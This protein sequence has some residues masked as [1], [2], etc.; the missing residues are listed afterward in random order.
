VGKPLEIVLAPLPASTPRESLC[1]LLVRV[2]SQPARSQVNSRTHVPQELT[3][4]ISLYTNP[5]S[6]LASLF[7]PSLKARNPLNRLMA[8]FV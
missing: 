1:A 7:K 4:L 8:G 5:V 6:I 2:A 3:G